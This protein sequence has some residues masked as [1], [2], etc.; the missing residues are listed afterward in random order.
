MGRIL[1]GVIVGILLFPAGIFVWFSRGKVPVSVSDPPIP[2]ESTLT[3]IPLH[4]RIGKELIQMPAVQPTEA[5]YV[6]GAKVYAR[7]CAVCHG[8]HGKS[9]PLGERMY[10]VAPPLWEK[11]RN[12]PAVGVSDDQPGETYWKIANGI[13]LTGMPEFRTLLSDEEMWQGSVLLSNADKPLPPAVL[14]ILRGEGGA[15]A[16]VPNADA[17]NSGQ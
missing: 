7:Y 12:S 1:F 3:Q 8:F 5:N 11:H 14:S 6:A 17:V 10:P 13:R 9:A 16:K 4:K 2:Y 15:A